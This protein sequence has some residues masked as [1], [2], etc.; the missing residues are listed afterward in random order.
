MFNF[1][2]TQGAQMAKT[3]GRSGQVCCSL[4]PGHVLQVWQIS[5]HKLL[6][7]WALA[8]LQQTTLPWQFEYTHYCARSELS[9]AQQHLWPGLLAASRLLPITA[10]TSACLPPA[11]MVVRDQ[12]QAAVRAPGTQPCPHTLQA[13]T[14]G[15]FMRALLR[16]Y[17]SGEEGLNPSTHPESFRRVLSRIRHPHHHP[18]L[19]PDVLSHCIHIPVSGPCSIG[20]QRCPFA[21]NIRAGGIS[22]RSSEGPYCGQG[23]VSM[24]CHRASAIAEIR[25]SRS[26]S[27]TT[28]VLTGGRTCPSPCWAPSA[29]PQA[30]PACQELWNGGQAAFS[31]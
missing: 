13:R 27:L 28:L 22:C 20:S 30:C 10:R 8:P 26:Q 29:Q 11:A 7:P 18:H 16:V 3:L 14:P 24:A 12:A 4:N 23:H 19:V 1:L 6:L 9:L 5:L 31:H 17:G 2:A 21:S 25:L 15:D